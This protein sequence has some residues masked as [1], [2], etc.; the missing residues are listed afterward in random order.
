M[1]ADALPR[2]ADARR[3]ASDY[4]IS[5]GH[6]YNIYTFMSNLKKGTITA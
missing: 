5:Y 4:Q 6:G 1:Q 2:A 3:C